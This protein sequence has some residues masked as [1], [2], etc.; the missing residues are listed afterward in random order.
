MMQKVFRSFLPVVLLVGLY[1]CGPSLSQKKDESAI[2]YRL[3]VVHLNDR[4]LT[5]A[6]KELT[7]AVEMYPGDASYHN[8][9]GLAYFAKGMNKEALKEMDRAI[10]IDPELSEA[11]VN[12]SA[13]YIVERDWDSA[14]EESK[15]ALKNIF[16]RTPEFAHFNMGWAYHS[17]GDY[18]SAVESYRKA[19]QANPGY[20]LAYYNMGLSFEKLNSMR[21]A[22]SSYEN[23]IKVSPGYIDAHFSLGMALIKNKDK[24]SAVKAFEKVI[25][26]APESGKAQSAREYINLIK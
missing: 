1:S 6:L 18:Q 9:L 8:A 21:D 7:R 2:H 15:A 23:A 4:N 26:I 20:P 17:K 16:Y 24:A 12:K 19:V 5:D 25:E 11:R 14:I 13:V 10:K 22:I 3:G